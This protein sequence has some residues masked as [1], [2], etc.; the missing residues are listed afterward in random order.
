MFYVEG[1]KE[2]GLNLLGHGITG[3]NFW[4][5]L[6]MLIVDFFFKSVH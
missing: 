6:I 5:G 2:G 3:R 1:C 4:E